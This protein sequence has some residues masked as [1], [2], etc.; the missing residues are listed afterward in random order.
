[1]KFETLLAPHILGEDALLSSCFIDG[2][3]KAVF[4]VFFVLT[5]SPVLRWTMPLIFSLQGCAQ[6]HL[7]PVY[8]ARRLHY[9]EW[10]T[11]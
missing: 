11:P 9:G 3:S 5:V 8:P 7:L 10:C 4:T 2:A 6:A 1:M